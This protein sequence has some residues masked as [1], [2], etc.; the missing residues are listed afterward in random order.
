LHSA[1]DLVVLEILRHEF[2]TVLAVVIDLQSPVIMSPE[3]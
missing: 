2:V 3:I 1:G